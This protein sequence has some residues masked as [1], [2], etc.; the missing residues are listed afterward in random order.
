MPRDLAANYIYL[1]V[2][3]EAMRVVKTSSSSVSQPFKLVCFSES[4]EVAPMEAYG[5]T[6]AR[7]GFCAQDALHY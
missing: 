1:P 7:P 2:T 4:R 5:D 6:A 3:Y